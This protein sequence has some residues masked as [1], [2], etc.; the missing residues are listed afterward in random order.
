M[1]HFCTRNVLCEPVSLVLI[2]FGYIIRNLNHFVSYNSFSITGLKVTVVMC[3]LLMKITSNKVDNLFK[4]SEEFPSRIRPRFYDLKL[5]MWHFDLIWKFKY[6]W[7]YFS[8]LQ[9][10]I[11][12][13]YILGGTINIKDRKIT[14]CYVKW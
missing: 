12:E 6:R 9:K 13:M 5:E 7:L 10:Y 1:Q 8:T 3:S 2:L 11:S 14:Q 4:L